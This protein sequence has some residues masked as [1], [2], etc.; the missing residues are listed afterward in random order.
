MCVTQY[1]MHRQQNGGKAS[2]YKIVLLSGPCLAQEDLVSFI[3]LWADMPG[4]CSPGERMKEAERRGKKKTYL[5][6]N[7]GS[8]ASPK[9]A[10]GASASAKCCAVVARCEF[11]Q[12]IVP[13]ALFFF[14]KAQLASFSLPGRTMPTTDRKPSLSGL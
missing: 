6:T 2:K 14:L 13:S 3:C 10:D 7:H 1:C 8:A 4:I 5:C 11:L 9:S 12:T